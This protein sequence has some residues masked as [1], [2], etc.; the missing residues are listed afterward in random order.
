MPRPAAPHP[1]DRDYPALRA[2]GAPDLEVLDARLTGCRACPRLVAWREEAGRVRRAA[3]RDETYWARPVPGFGPA[4][5]SLA[6]IGLAPA[7]H[8]GNRTGR[9]FTGDPTSDFLFAALHAAHLAALP[10]S[11]SRDDGQWLYGTRLVSPV[12][13]VPPDNRPTPAE[14]DTC[15]PWMARELDLL[16]PTLRAA[17]VLGGFG[18]QALMPVLTAAGYVLPR[19]RP[20]FGHGAHAR[21]EGPDG[22]LHLLG[23]YHPSPRNTS[24]GRLT[25]Q[26]ATDVFRRAARLAGSAR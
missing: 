5:A 19:P 4:D 2:P 8:G 25:L 20:A 23:C 7:A 14:R 22:P 17:V 1:D 26:M 24:T 3:Y 18:W 6:V 9:L 15:R 11:H 16:G 10:Y 13:C 21:I 12:H